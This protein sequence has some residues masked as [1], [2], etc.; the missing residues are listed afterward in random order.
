MDRSTLKYSVLLAESQPLLAETLYDS[1][2]DSDFVSEIFLVQS[3]DLLFLEF[4]KNIP[5]VLLIGIDHSN[6]KTRLTNIQQIRRQNNAVHIIGI[7]SIEVPGFVRKAFLYGVNALMHKH[8]CS[9][10]EV[11]EVIEYVLM[12]KKYL[13]EGMKQNMIDE[14]LYPSIQSAA[15]MQKLKK[16]DLELIELL[17][18]G[19]TTDE[20]AEKL[21]TTIHVVS[22]MKRKLC[23][24]LD[25][26]NGPHLILKALTAHLINL[27]TITE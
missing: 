23:K 11:L 18:L 4:K 2:K 6:A 10:Q 14:I 3:D 5:D 16:E 27:E 8:E 7:S 20:I 17:A 22:A 9:S 15:L 25:A 19:K 1:L 13:S 24:R 26:K 21:E 12:G